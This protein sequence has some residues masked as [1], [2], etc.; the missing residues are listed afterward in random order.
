VS[1]ENAGTAFLDDLNRDNDRLKQGK[2][3]RPR[4]SMLQSS[5]AKRRPYESAVAKRSIVIDGYKTSAS[6]EYAFWTALKEIAHSQGVTV[7]KLVT[8][9]DTTCKQSHLSS[10]IRVFVLEHFQKKDKSADPPHSI[11]PTVSNDES[12]STQAWRG[13]ARRG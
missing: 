10:A 4:F 12:R 13:F 8:A 6:L 9:I 1:N 2:T 5:A 3:M 11:R 7:S